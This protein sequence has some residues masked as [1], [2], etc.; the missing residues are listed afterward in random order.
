MRKSS[1]Y[2]FLF[3]LFLSCSVF[4]EEVGV[5]KWIDVAIRNNLSLNIALKKV[6]LSEG[7]VCQARRSLFPELIFSYE[8][9]VGKVDGLEYDGVSYKGKLKNTIF[10]GGRKVFA[11]SR[12]EMRLEKT[13]KEYEKL[14]REIVLKGTKA[15]WK[16]VQTT[17]SRETFENTFKDVEVLADGAEKVYQ[18]GLITQQEY[19]EIKS[20]FLK[21][22]VKKSTLEKDEKIALLEF[23]HT[24]NLKEEEPIDVAEEIPFRRVVVEFSKLWEQAQKNRM[25]WQVTHLDKE[26]KRLDLLI[27]ERG[28]WPEAG[29]SFSYGSS[30]EAYRFNR[31]DLSD[32]WQVLAEVTLNIG[33]NSLK[34]KY[35]KEDFAPVV[36][37]FRGDEIETHSIDFSLLDKLDK[38]NKIREEEIEL[39]EA[40]EEKEKEE[41][42]IRREVEEAYYNLRKAAI[43]VEA[44]LKEISFR[45]K[46]AEIVNLKR[47]LGKADLVELIKAKVSLGE[48][49]ISYFGALAEHAIAIAEIEHAVGGL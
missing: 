18:E 42:K 9:K 22:L 16:L 47:G 23:R 24:I 14:R 34:Y 10:D 5:E 46:D 17:L 48:A 15:Y 28:K 11:L 6:K 31:L 3:V 20:Q 7:R 35:D 49:R 13:K 29:V 38:D 8:D 32:E 40:N 36:G 41:K 43:N 21:I 12:E 27:A 44:A 30:G 39:D 33:A 4:A 26:M 1:L 45:E 25:E 37:S 19:L 2:F